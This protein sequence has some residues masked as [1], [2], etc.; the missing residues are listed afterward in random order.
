[1]LKWLKNLFHRKPKRLMDVV[2]EADSPEQGLIAALTFLTGGTVSAYPMSGNFDIHVYDATQDRYN[3]FYQIP[4]DDFE[5]ID[6]FKMTLDEFA[7]KFGY[8]DEPTMEEIRA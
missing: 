1:M 2:L 5:P 4:L 6:V 7:D 8:R 3:G